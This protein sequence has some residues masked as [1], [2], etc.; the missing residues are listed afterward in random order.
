VT[1]LAGVNSYFFLTLG[2]ANPDGS[3][4]SLVTQFDLELRLVDISEAPFVTTTLADVAISTGTVGPDGCLYSS[5][6]DTVYR[7]SKDDGTCPFLPTS[8]APTLTISPA[9]VAPS[10]LQGGT[11][12]FAAWL[13]NV[14]DP[15]GTPVTFGITGANAGFA[16]A[17]ADANGVATLNLV[18]VFSG[19]DG[20]S[21]AATVEGRDV[22]SNRTQITWGAGMH[23][24]ELSLNASPESGFVGHSSTLVADLVDLSVEPSA[25][26]VGATV[27][28]S[29][30]GEVCQDVTDVAG[31]A[32]CSVTFDIVGESTL[33]ATYA[34][35]LGNLGATA[36]IGF[37]IGSFGGSNLI[38]ADDFE[39]GDTDAW[40]GTF[41]PNAKIFADDFET[42]N[43]VRWS[44]SVPPA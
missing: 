9:P 10:G 11:Q 24:S 30:G 8:P 7:L 41:A 29:V 16:L 23:V 2:E 25:P 31:R 26:I 4:K 37:S 33:V 3:A 5:G 13:R 17:Q 39:T 14:D 34:G 44:S 38:F 32:S 20:V 42:G 28:F 15:E 35:D 27:E 6:S 36:S 40:S 12:Q 43:L 18:G 21:A 1:T 22:V 19:T